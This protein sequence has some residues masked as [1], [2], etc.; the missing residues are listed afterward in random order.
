MISCDDQWDLVAHI[1][2]QRD[3]QAF[4]SGEGRAVTVA[5]A[6]LVSDLVQRVVVGENELKALVD[7]TSHTLHDGG[8][9][10]P[11]PH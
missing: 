10:A 11:S 1:G 9:I 7:R 4:Y 8:H 3:G 2:A 6:E 5:Q